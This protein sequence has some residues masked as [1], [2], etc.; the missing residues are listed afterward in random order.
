MYG[1]LSADL[2]L[3]L[4]ESRPDRVW[5][6]ER[7]SGRESGPVVTQCVR[8]RSALPTLDPGFWRQVDC[9]CPGWERRERSAR[10]CT[11][12][13]SWRCGCAAG[14]MRVAKHLFDLASKEMRPRR[15]LSRQFIL[16]NIPGQATEASDDALSAMGAAEFFHPSSIPSHTQVP[17]PIRPSTQITIFRLHQ[18]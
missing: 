10:V 3:L 14:A 18:K 7:E 16:V 1:C 5:P 15:R 2:I 13:R 9:W 6:P 11:H 8:G 12:P 4:A 17:N